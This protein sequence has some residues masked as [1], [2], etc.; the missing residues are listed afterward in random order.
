MSGRG[1]GRGPDSRCAPRLPS[2]AVPRRPKNKPPRPE[3]KTPAG[4]VAGGGEW[5]EGRLNDTAPQAA[6][7]AQGVAKRALILIRRHNTTPHAVARSQQIAIESLYNLIK[8]RSWPNLI[9]VARLEIHF[10]R[11]LWGHEHLCGHPQLKAPRDYTAPGEQWPQGALAADAPKEARLAQGIAKTALRHIHRCDTTPDAV[12]HKQQIAVETLHD[13]ING[14]T[15]P[16]F[17]TVARLE[18]HFNRRLWG[19]E[20]KPR[21]HK[22]RS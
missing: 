3:H 13:L 9:T 16:D 11:R 8:G 6:R 10:N 7:L 1:G 21:R 22:P 19:H 14:H 15:W 12:A 2:P 17:I 5:T 18:I 4:H 20:H